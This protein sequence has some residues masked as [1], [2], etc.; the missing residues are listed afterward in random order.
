MS[1]HNAISFS[2]KF[3][4]THTESSK[5]RVAPKNNLNLDNDKVK[6]F[7]YSEVD[8][9]INYAFESIINSNFQITVY[10]KEQMNELYNNLCKVYT[11]SYEES[12]KFQNLS[13]CNSGEKNSNVEM[14]KDMKSCK[15]SLLK[16]YGKLK[17]NPTNEN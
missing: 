6:K 1:D 8:S 15:K 4:Y 7:F 13:Q 11:D 12:L 5:A 14:S 2:F 16:T 17:A 9:R 3:S 10:N